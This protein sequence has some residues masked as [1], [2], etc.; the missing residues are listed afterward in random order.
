MCV[1]APLGLHPSLSRS[2]P[3]PETLGGEQGRM[4]LL[5]RAGPD[6][7]SICAPPL[8]VPVL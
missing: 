2:G 3:C 5:S 6:G 1:H 7:A 4:S 8:Q